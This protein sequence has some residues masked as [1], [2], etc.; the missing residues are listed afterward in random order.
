MQVIPANDPLTIADRLLSK[1]LLTT[2]VYAGLQDAN[3]SNKE[4][5]RK[6][7][8]QLLAIFLMQF[9]KLSRSST[10]EK[11]ERRYSGMLDEGKRK[12][13]SLITFTIN[14]S[15][16]CFVFHHTASEFL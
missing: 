6:I 5:A 12:F 8:C 15:Y 2:K 7:V 3:Y 10:L 13:T 4:R 16:F 11:L 1:G 14:M 9:M